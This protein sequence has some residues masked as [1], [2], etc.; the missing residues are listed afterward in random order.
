MRLPALALWPLVDAYKWLQRCGDEI[1]PERLLYLPLSVSPESL[2][3]T[4]EA[5]KYDFMLT[6]SMTGV[7][8]MR[9][10][11][12]SFK[13]TFANLYFDRKR[14]M[15]LIVQ[16]DGKPFKV[17]DGGGSA[18][19]IRLNRGTITCNSPGKAVSLSPRAGFIT[20]VCQNIWNMPVWACR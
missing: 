12:A 3:L 13:H 19:C 5:I 15:D 1:Q 8:L 18:I 14:L 2:P 16:F 6:G 10:A 9:D 4:H 11:Y 7:W 20:P 17:Y